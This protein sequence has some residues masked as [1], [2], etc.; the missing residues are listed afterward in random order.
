MQVKG[1]KTSAITDSSGVFTLNAPAGAATLVFTYVGMD[2]KEVSI[3][4][5][6]DFQIELKA[7]D[8]SL[9]EVV[10]V[11]YGAQRKPNLTGA[12]EVFKPKD[13]E[14]L[15]VGNLGAA[16]SGRILGLAVSG[17]TARPGSTPNLTVRNPI[18]LSKDGGTLDPLYVIDGMVHGFR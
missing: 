6:T 15:P 4:G 17:G 16:L 14:D 13:V 3:S 18:T 1:L 8:A 9:S 5:K 2:R 11:G 10:V 12:V 7:A